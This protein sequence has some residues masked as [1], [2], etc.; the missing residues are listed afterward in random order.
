ML[1]QLFI[2][3][4]ML[5]CQPL[6]LHRYLNF[7]PLHQLLQWFHL[8]VYSQLLQWFRL[9]VDHPLILTLFLLFLITAWNLYGQ[10]FLFWKW[11]HWYF[12]FF[13]NNLQFFAAVCLTWHHYAGVLD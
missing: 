5:L 11:L 6:L 4:L 7:E 3:R 10:L 8:L 2:F 13:D 9:Q 1:I 12:F